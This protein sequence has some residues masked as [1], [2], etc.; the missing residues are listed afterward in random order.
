MSC[1]SPA[2]WGLTS[3]ADR[4]RLDAFL[5]RPTALGFSPP[6]APNAGRNT[7]S[8]RTSLS[9]NNFINRMLYE[10]IWH[11]FDNYFILMYPLSSV[12]AVWL[13]HVLNY[14]LLTYLLT[15]SLTYLS[16][17][18][19]IQRRGSINHS[20]TWI[21]SIG[22]PW[23]NI[24]DSL[25]TEHLYK[26]RRRDQTNPVL[27]ADCEIRP[28]MKPL[29]DRDRLSIAGARALDENNTRGCYFHRDTSIDLFRR[30]DRSL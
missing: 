12:S 20:R 2:W 10:N 4:D 18:R 29:R 19:S 5:T 24:P 30:T 9:D 7:L 23:K 15:Y 16:T 13:L 6:T 8:I 25:I 27:P 17:R 1:A 26:D 28:F 21:I 22:R 3:A 14:Y 11:Y